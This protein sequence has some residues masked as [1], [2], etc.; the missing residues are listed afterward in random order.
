VV[1]QRLLAFGAVVACAA[2]ISLAPS[3]VFAAA[4]P[5]ASGLPTAAS[6]VGQSQVAVPP[7]PTAVLP[8]TAVAGSGAPIPTTAAL[9]QQLLPLLQSPSLGGRGTLTVVDAATGKMLLDSDGSR[10][11]LPASSLKVLTTATAL[12]LLG[13][14]TR[15]VTKVVRGATAQQIVLVGGGD[16]TLTRAPSTDS[17]PGQRLSYASLT[18]LATATAKALQAAGT[19]TV[20]LSYDNSLFTGPTVASGWSTDFVAS[21]EV[22]PV[23]ALSADSGR[24]SANSNTRSPDPAKAAA[25][26]FAGALQRVGI[27]VGPTVVRATAGTSAAVVAEVQSPTV[28]DLVERTLTESD[29]DLAEALSHLSGV[30]IGDGSFAGGAA[31]VEQTLTLLGIGHTGMVIRDGSGLSNQDRVPA[32]VFAQTLSLA[33]VA[34]PKTVM[35]WPLLTGMP[36]AGVTGT[37]TSRFVGPARAGRGVVR[38]KTGT[39]TGVSALAGTVRSSTGRVLTFCVMSDAT[40]STYNARATL[41]QVA[42]AIAAA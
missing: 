24:I 7:A 16:Q 14:D 1:G 34:G 39:L 11:Q 8:A 20:A 41:D 26:Y 31:A 38:A 9:Q 29:N 4:T 37:L 18:G 23:D 42:A 22:S 27:T 25:N 35:M 19:T 15:L 32:N 36:I 30:A 33:A 5:S 13:P 21:G 3:A 28:A 12:R 40:T 10:A 2:S 6:Q 17:P